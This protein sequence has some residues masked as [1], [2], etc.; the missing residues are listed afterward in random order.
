M[1]YGR[2][3]YLEPHLKLPTPLLRR[4]RCVL[5]FL[6][7]IH[8]IWVA[9]AIPP[10]DF[11]LA[12]FYFT[13]WPYFMTAVHLLIFVY[14]QAD[15][16]FTR[17]FSTIYYAALWMNLLFSFIYLTVFVLGSQSPADHPASPSTVLLPLAA[18][19]VEAVCNRILIPHKRRFVAWLAAAGYFLLSYAYFVAEGHSLYGNRLKWNQSETWVVVAVVALWGYVF[20]QTIDLFQTRKFVSKSDLLFDASTK[21]T[22]LV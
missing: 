3:S 22:G 19:S 7:V 13:N 11:P 9:L 12:P 4:I 8:F 6:F 1:D 14:T 10:S 21:D 18:M 16:R 15:W 17:R 5:L 2:L 20:D